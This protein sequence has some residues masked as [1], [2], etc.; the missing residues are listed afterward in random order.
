M[1]YYKQ[2]DM[3][4]YLND[5]IQR[6]RE[7]NQKFT[8][9]KK[10]GKIF[11]YVLE[12]KKLVAAAQASLS[13][14]WISIKKLFYPNLK[15]LKVLIGEIQNYFSE[16]VGIKLYTPIPSRY[17]DFISIGF[18]DSTEVDMNGTLWYYASLYEK[19]DYP[20]YDEK[21]IVSEEAVEPYQNQLINQQNNFDET[22]KIDNTCEEIAYVALDDDKFIGGITL[23]VSKDSVYTHLLVVDNNY[24]GKDIGSKLMSLAEDLA[25]ERNIKLLEV[26]TTDFQA[27]SFYKKMGYKV[28]Y[29]RRDNPKGYNCYTM[30]KII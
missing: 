21:I 3:F 16:S 17:K 1:I 14:D 12:N 2:D 28:I 18:V 11:I 25:K 26:G 27:P 24:R 10:E 30:M 15:T 6:L 8:G 5:I 4:Q 19:V 23:E 9:I 20:L 7:H 22:N 13:W 29:T